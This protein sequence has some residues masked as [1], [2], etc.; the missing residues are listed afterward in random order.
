MDDPL[1]Y[2]RIKGGNTKKQEKNP[3]KDAATTGGGIIVFLVFT[4]INFLPLL[5]G[6]TAATGVIGFFTGS[7]NALR[8]LIVGVVALLVKPTLGA[9]LIKIISR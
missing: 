2:Y 1:D 3:L 5:G 8:L 7:D 6:L 9:I 4:I